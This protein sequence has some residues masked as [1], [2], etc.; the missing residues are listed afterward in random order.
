DAGSNDS[1]TSGQAA[2]K[3]CPNCGQKNEGSKFCPNCGQKLS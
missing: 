2:P 3:F 1:D